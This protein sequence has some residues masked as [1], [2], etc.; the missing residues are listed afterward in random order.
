MANPYRVPHC[1][2]FRMSRP[3]DVTVI[4]YHNA[5]TFVSPEEYV[6]GMTSPHI[7][8]L[9]AFACGQ[10]MPCSGKYLNDKFL[11]QTM[12]QLLVRN[13]NMANAYNKYPFYDPSD[14]SVMWTAPNMYSNPMG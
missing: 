13:K 12:E 10:T 7:Q 8:G 3:S 1:S 5:Y 4:P 6:K 9:N 14:P 2:T 11:G